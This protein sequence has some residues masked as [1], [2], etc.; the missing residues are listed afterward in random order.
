MYFSKIH[1]VF[2]AKFSRV[3]AAVRGMCVLWLNISQLIIY[4]KVISL[5]LLLPYVYMGT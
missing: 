5:L 1:S 4:N 3:K 2:L